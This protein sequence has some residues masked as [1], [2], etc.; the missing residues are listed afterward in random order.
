MT[1]DYIDKQNKDTW[2]YSSNLSSSIRY[3]YW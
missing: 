3:I 1:I 2:H